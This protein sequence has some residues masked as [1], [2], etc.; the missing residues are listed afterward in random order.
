MQDKTVQINCNDS[1]CWNGYISQMRNQVT[2][3][4]FLLTYDQLATKQFIM[5]PIC[6][7]Y[8]K[9]GIVVCYFE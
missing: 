7:S 2:T 5:Q 4:N 3:I 1:Q 9:T 6:Q 8:L